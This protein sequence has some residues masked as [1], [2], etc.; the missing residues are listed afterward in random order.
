MNRNVKIAKELVK[1]A[2]SLVCSELIDAGY[3]LK[4]PFSLTK[5]SQG[6]N[7]V[8]DALKNG[9]DCDAVIMKGEDKGG[10]KNFIRTDY[11][12]STDIHGEIVCCKNLEDKKDEILKEIRKEQ[13]KIKKSSGGGDG[14]PIVVEGNG[15]WSCSSVY[16]TYPIYTVDKVKVDGEEIRVFWDYSMK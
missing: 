12:I 11:F 15:K 14:Q 4:H 16:G 13:E 6:I 9:E 5:N 2:K 8:Q 10:K 3:S 1:L 7:E